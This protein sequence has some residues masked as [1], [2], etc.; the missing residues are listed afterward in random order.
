MVTEYLLKTVISCFVCTMQENQFLLFL[1]HLR[2]PYSIPKSFALL[3]NIHSAR[4]TF[5]TMML[6]LGADLFTTS[7]LM[8]HT[9]IQTTEIYAKIVD[10]KKEEAINLIDGMFK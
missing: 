3:L 8:G 7:K 9:N 5:G 2:L 6:T 10:K 4:H 1:N